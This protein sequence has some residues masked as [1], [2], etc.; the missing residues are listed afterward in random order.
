MDSAV[1]NEVTYNVGDTIE[2]V[3]S[4]TGEVKNFGKI[5]KI[6]KHRDFPVFHF[7]NS[8]GKEC[9]VAPYAMLEYHLSVRKQREIKLAMNVD[10]TGDKLTVEGKFQNLALSTEGLALVRD[11]I[12]ESIAELI[13]DLEL[14]GQR[15]DID[16]RSDSEE[17]AINLVFGGFNATPEEVEKMKEMVKEFSASVLQESKKWM[18]GIVHELK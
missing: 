16:V 13:R 11:V 17:V 4:V 6:E 2:V 14:H 1:W 8:S 18:E 9:F 10:V 7:E 3:G 5:T 12:K 15:L